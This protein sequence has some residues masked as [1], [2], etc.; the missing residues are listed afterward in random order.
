MIKRETRTCFDLRVGRG[1]EHR[2]QRHE[3]YMSATTACIPFR[4]L[5][6]SA[7]PESTAAIVQNISKS[8]CMAEQLRDFKMAV[9]TPCH[10]NKKP[11]SVKSSSASLLLPDPRLDLAW[12][13][14][15]LSCLTTTIRW[16]N[17]GQIVLECYKYDYP[18][19]R[20]CHSMAARGLV[21]LTSKQMRRL[22]LVQAY[23]M[24][25]SSQGRLLEGASALCYFAP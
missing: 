3:R 5:S 2:H 14:L 7:S 11:P 13:S 25:K 24:L 23:R 21:L 4:T 22:C 18:N 9:Q 8:G 6:C 17:L 19:G 12:I 16:Q 1:S 20:R 10:F 15:G